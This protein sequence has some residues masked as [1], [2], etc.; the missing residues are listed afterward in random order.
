MLEIGIDFF[1]PFRC[2]DVLL[3]RPKQD[4][5]SAIERARSST[6]CFCPLD[7]ELPMSPMR[8]IVAHRHCHDIVVDAGNCAHRSSIAD[9]MLFKKADVSAIDPDS[10]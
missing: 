9:R 6:R 3:P 10:N 8:A 2:P 5:W 7:N 4:L 1:F